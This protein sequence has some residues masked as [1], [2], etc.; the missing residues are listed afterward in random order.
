MTRHD[1]QPE[2]R[3]DRIF[4]S[5]SRRFLLIFLFLFVLIIRAINVETYV[6]N[7]A[8]VCYRCSDGVD[9][10]TAQIPSFVIALHNIRVMP[11][12]RVHLKVR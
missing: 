1:S 9:T 10:A 8:Y 5:F 2:F 3:Y 11:H 4:H 7:S 6:Y 12:G